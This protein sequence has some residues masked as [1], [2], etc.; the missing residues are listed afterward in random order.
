MAIIEQPAGTGLAIPGAGGAP[1]VTTPKTAYGIFKRPVASTG[2]RDWV[3]TVDHK[4]LGIMYGVVAFTFFIVGGLEALLI[5]AQLFQP[6]GK[7]LNADQYNQMFTMH[8]TTMIFLF[9]MPMVSALANYF[10]PLQI[11]ARD[12]AFPRINAL[13][14]WIVL[15]GGIFVNL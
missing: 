10:I 4:K 12:V 3:V 13:G 14:F 11:G 15:F 9:V 6:N 5:R 8:A 2:W 7:V 1:A